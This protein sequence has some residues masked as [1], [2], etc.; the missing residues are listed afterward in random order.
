MKVMRNGVSRPHNLKML[1]YPL[2]STQEKLLAAALEDLMDPKA[3]LLQRTIKI[4]YWINRFHKYGMSKGK[5][6]E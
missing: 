4:Q 3:T 2:D 5:L 1:D 6:D